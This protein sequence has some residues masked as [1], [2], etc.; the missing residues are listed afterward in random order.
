MICGMKY[1]IM[2]Y[3]RDTGYIGERWHEMPFCKN[4]FKRAHYSHGRYSLFIVFKHLI[5]R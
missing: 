2:T 5:A 3:H 4:P 1:M